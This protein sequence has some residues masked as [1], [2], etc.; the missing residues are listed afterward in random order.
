M[1]QYY[2]IEQFIVEHELHLQ[3]QKYRPT[4]QITQKLEVCID[5]YLGSKY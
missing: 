1:I 3:G 4:S 2:L 5:C